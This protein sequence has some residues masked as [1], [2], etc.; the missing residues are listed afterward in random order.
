MSSL[1]GY[2]FGARIRKYR[3][4]LDLT[5]KELAAKL[6]IHYN[7]LGDI[8]RGKVDTGLRLTAYIIQYLNFT[9]EDLKQIFRI[10]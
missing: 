2:Q 1:P 4:R 7:H 6:E 9:V 8:E 5:Q 10:K 3:K